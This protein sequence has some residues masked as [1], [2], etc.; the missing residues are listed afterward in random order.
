MKKW[1]IAILSG[2]FGIHAP[3]ALSMLREIGDIRRVVPRKGISDEEMA[4]IIGDAQAVILGA[5]GRITENVLERTP[6]L[7][8]IARHGVGLDNIDLKAATKHEVVVTYTPHANSESVAEHTF[9]IILALLRRICEARR[10]VLSGMWHKRSTFIGAELRGKVLGII[11]LGSIGKRV[12]EIARLGFN[13]SIMAYDPYVPEEVARK[14]GVKLTDLNTLLESSDIITI[15]A[16]LSPE[17]HH[18]IGEK[19]FK[20]MKPSAII[21]NTARGGIVDEKALVKA[22]RERWIAGAALDVMEEEPPDR[23]NPLL[24]M[25]NVLITPHIAAFT[26]EAL[27]RMDMMIVEDIRRIHSGLVPL[28]VANSEV[29]PMLGLKRS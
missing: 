23:G 7:R 15:H 9:A 10:A 13:M 24:N 8:V 16:I 29:I 12:A 6:D 1:H 21:V 14:L 26:L 2:S 18:M 25:D 28:R 3:E 20:R 27:K 17:T 5:S 19:E 22:L 11:G 4:S